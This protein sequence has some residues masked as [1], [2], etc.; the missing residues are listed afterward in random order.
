MQLTHLS[1]QLI[2]NLVVGD[3]IDFA[4]TNPEQRPGALLGVLAQSDAGRLSGQLATRISVE[5]FV[6]AALNY[7][8]VTADSKR[9]LSIMG[10]TAE[11]R[12]KNLLAAAFKSANSR[13]VELAERMAAGGRAVAHL[14][15]FTLVDG[16]FVTGSVGGAGAY[17]LRGNELFPFFSGENEGG[18]I[19]A[20]RVGKRR[21]VELELASV[22]VE[23]RDLIVI[24]PDRCAAGVSRAAARAGVFFAESPAAI[25]QVDR[26][27]V[28]LLG[29][30]GVC[31]RAAIV[32]RVGPKTLYLQSKS[33]I[34]GW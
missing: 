26:D 34:P 30:A 15:G 17:L 10:D 8:S 1:V 2:D 29:E 31:Q 11:Q 5:E 6:S 9:Q 4:V 24:T 13:I 22:E 19:G 14:V 18:S 7:Y 25:A 3:Q 20:E 12:G 32:L 33:R 16:W 21:E 28:A 23:P 27:L